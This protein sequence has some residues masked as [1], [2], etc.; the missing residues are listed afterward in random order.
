MRLFHRPGLHEAALG[1]AKAMRDTDLT[2]VSFS[3]LVTLNH[4]KFVRAIENELDRPLNAMEKV[5]VF[6]FPIEH[7][8]AR[9]T[10]RLAALD[11]DTMN[12][13]EQLVNEFRQ[14]EPQRHTLGEIPE[15]PHLSLAVRLSFLWSELLDEAK[16][17]GQLDSLMRQIETLQEEPLRSTKI[18]DI[19]FAQDR[20][21][22][23]IRTLEALNSN[24]EDVLAILAQFRHLRGEQARL[25]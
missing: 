18:A 19:L 20:L 7:D 2:T 4:F 21:S 11:P 5:R 9:L 22:E 17:H 1:F 16:D 25:A 12:L 15:I 3:A 13:L 23:A 10:A 14:A 6:Q 24:D 8:A